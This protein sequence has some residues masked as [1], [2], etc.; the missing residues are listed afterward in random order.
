[1]LMPVLARVAD[2]YGGRFHLAKVNTDAERE[3]ATEYGIRSLPTVKLFRNA[4]VVDEFLG[5]QPESAI[6]ALIDRHLPRSADPIIERALAALHTGQADQ[7]LQLLRAA[8][9]E[10]T[11]YDRPKIE[12]VR[13]LLALPLDGNNAERLA[14][15]EKLLGSLSAAKRADPEVAALRTRL[16]FLR[17]AASAPPLAQLEH[18]LAGDPTNAEARYQL[19]AY[20]V[21]TGDYEP[22]M[23]Q[24]LEVVRRDRRFGDD[25]GRKGLVD[26][27]TL[28]GNNDPLVAKYRGLLSRA[29]N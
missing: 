13:Q 7:A 18:A 16:Q 12:L 19:S 25:A 17:V 28:L 26:L 20:K 11:S 2:D 8:V 9:A 10:D 3:L 1:M 29:L 4:A 5:V 23:Q 22:A 14:E 27:F 6:R 24:L 15:S 21:L